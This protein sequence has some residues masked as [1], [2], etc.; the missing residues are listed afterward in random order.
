[1][2]EPRQGY[3][4]YCEHCT[5]VL[6][7]GGN[8]RKVRQSQG[9]SLRKMADDLGYT[10]AYFSDIELNRRRVRIA[11]GVGKKIADYLGIEA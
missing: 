1:M 5:A 8:I 10:P 2:V 9:I 3:C 11:D 7:D 4:P 6:M